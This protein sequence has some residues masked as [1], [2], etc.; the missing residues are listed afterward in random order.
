MGELLQDIA[1]GW[2]A[3]FGKAPWLA[4][5]SH[6][7]TRVYYSRAGAKT[8]FLAQILSETGREIEG[9]LALYE[10]DATFVDEP[11][12]VVHGTDALRESI[13]AFM[14]LKPSL[15]LVKYE[16]LVAGV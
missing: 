7:L 8:R 2:P 16:A 11:G 3:L 10:P 9:V 6:H 13:S 12:K 5:I 15:T 1:V 4:C 14:A